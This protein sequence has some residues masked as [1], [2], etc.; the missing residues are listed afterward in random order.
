MGER[1]MDREAGK[2]HIGQDG[3][4]EKWR[5]KRKFRESGHLQG[6]MTKYYRSKQFERS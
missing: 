2:M 6:L 3:V 5:E 4:T 1:K